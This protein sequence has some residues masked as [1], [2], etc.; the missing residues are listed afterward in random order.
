M[1]QTECVFIQMVQSMIRFIDYAFLS[2]RLLQVTQISFLNFHSLLSAELYAV[3]LANLQTFR[4]NENLLILTDSL[5]TLK[6]LP[7]LHDQI[8]HLIAKEIISILSYPLFLLYR[9][10]SHGYR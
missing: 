6:Y 2:D 9:L 8:Q 4:L 3:K 10:S 7:N 1:I 5:S